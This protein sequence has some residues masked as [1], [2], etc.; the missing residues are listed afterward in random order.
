MS[1]LAAKAGMEIE[2]WPEARAD[3][4]GRARL[5]VGISCVG[6]MVVASSSALWV[7]LPEQRRGLRG[8]RHDHLESVVDR[9]SLHLR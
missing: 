5:W 8:E 3:G 9:V 7:G 2:G 1:T 4:Y 6:T